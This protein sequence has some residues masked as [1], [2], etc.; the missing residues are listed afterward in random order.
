MHHPEFSLEEVGHQDK[1]VDNQKSDKCH[2]RSSP[3]AVKD[4]VMNL[5]NRNLQRRICARTNPR[6]KF[7]CIIVMLINIEWPCI[8]KPCNSFRKKALG[9]KPKKRATSLPR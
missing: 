1:A 2:T 8:P 6:V 7:Q 3:D 4:H 9:I 5:P